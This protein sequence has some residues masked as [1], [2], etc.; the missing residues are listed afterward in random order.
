[1]NKNILE[2]IIQATHTAIQEAATPAIRQS[3]TQDEP[4]DEPQDDTQDDI[5]RVIQ[6][7][8]QSTL[9][10]TQIYEYFI[11]KCLQYHF[12]DDPSKINLVKNRIVMNFF[13]LEDIKM[14]F[15]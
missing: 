10:S 14:I 13:N 12:K 6:S 15:Q 9:Q 3:L 1:L 8:V 7:K 5:Q 4:Q 2:E 11:D